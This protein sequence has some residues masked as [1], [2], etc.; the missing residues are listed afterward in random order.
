MY[1]TVKLDKRAASVIHLSTAMDQI[2]F[3]AAFS[4]LAV[5]CPPH[6][7]TCVMVVVVVVVKWQ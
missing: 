7:Y 2:K 1:E 3:W 4:L 6:V 5:F